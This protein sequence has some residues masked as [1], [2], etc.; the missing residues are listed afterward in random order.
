MASDIWTVVGD[1]VGSLL[2][3]LTTRRVGVSASEEAL[4]QWIE[5]FEFDEPESLDALTVRVSRM[6]REGIVHVTSPRYFGLFNPSVLEVGMVADALAAAYNPQLAV[7]S[8]APVVAEME[9]RVLQCLAGVLGLPPDG[10]HANFT[11]GGAEANHSAVLVA[12]AQRYPDISRRG[13]ASLGTTPRIYLS[14]EAHHSF[15]KVARMTGLGT[16]ALRPVPTNEAF[17][18]DPFSLED[19]I[20]RDL[21]EGGDPL[22]VVATVGTTACGAVDPLIEIADVAR[23]FRT[24]L[25]VDAAWGGAAGFSPRLRPLLAGIERADSVT[26]DAHKWLSV[27]MGAGMFFTRHPD[28]VRRAFSIS[29]SYIPRSIARDDADGYTTTMQWSR[30]AIGLKVLMSVAHLGLSGYARLIDHQTDMG[31]RLRALLTGAGWETVNATPL[32]LVCFTHPRIADG[33]LSTRDVLEFINARGRVWISDVKLKD[34]DPVLRACITSY[35]TEAADLRCLVDELE[36]AV[37]ARG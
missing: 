4:A 26:W 1:E 20:R 12:L 33:E 24:W 15:V 5:S 11:T 14:E 19:R 18:L 7:H 23:R 16:S 2:H 6:I 32:P 35:R 9:Q 28:A 8:H 3:D 27:P 22:L 30:R 36:R 21:E 13:I 25:H 34:R 17:A 31:D 29:A 37:A 10:T